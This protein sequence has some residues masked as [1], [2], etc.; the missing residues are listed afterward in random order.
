MPIYKSTGCAVNVLCVLLF[1]S[2]LFQKN[3][4]VQGKA[5]KTDKICGRSFVRREVK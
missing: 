1:N 3:T 2:E 4:V 5:I